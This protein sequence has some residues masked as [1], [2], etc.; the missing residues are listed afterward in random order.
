MHSTLAWSIFSDIFRDQSETNKNG[1]L[2]SKYSQTGTLIVLPQI[3]KN[4]ESV[5]RI[6]QICYIM[7]MFNVQ[8]RWHFCCFTEQVVQS[9]QYQCISVTFP[10]SL[11]QTCLNVLCVSQVKTY[12]R[13]Q[14]C[15]QHYIHR[16]FTASNTPRSSQER[17]ITKS[18][19]S[20]HTICLHDPAS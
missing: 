2:G 12:L 4:L 11:G 17:R 1:L 5:P 15:L 16:A 10:S 13:S 3:W 19:T 8:T 6:M 20:T 7:W 9:L 18:R 14:A